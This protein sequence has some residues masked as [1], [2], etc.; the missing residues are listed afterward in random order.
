MK[1]VCPMCS[2]SARLLF[3]VSFAFSFRFRRPSAWERGHCWVNVATPCY[4]HRPLWGGSVLCVVVLYTY[5]GWTKPIQ[6]LFLH[7]PLLSPL[8]FGARQLENAAIV[9]SSWQRP[10]MLIDPYEEGLSYVQWLNKAY[11]NT[12]SPFSFAFFEILAPVSLKTRPSLCRHGNALPC[13]STLM[14]R[15]CPMC[16]GLAR[17]CIGRDRS[18][19][20]WTQGEGYVYDRR[21]LN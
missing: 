15:V 17:P 2:G 10:S 19:S 4:A 7:F 3:T 11:T 21:H 18:H 5:S 9:V 8:D 1:R 16:S 20:I 14:R 6:I 13:S 12:L